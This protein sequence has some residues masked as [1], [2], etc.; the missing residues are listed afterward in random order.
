MKNTVVQLWFKG[1]QLE[2][3]Q[4][5]FI[6]AAALAQVVKVS[7]RWMTLQQA[8]A[9]VVVC[10][11][12]VSNHHV[13]YISGICIHPILSISGKPHMWPCASRLQLTPNDQNN[14]DV[15]VEVSPVRKLIVDVWHRSAEGF[16][17]SLKNN[18]SLKNVRYA[19]IDRNHKNVYWVM[20]RQW[21]LR[22]NS[23]AYI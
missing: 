16:W 12:H 5:S 18:L 11:W 19:K 7:V 21:I 1:A 20:W 17:L 8:A 3:L 15:K 2:M 22:S 6:C 23:G 9:R 10:V 14:K 13:N 4:N